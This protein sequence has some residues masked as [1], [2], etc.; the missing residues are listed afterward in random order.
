M[1]MWRGLVVVYTE[2]ERD[3]EMSEETEGETEDCA[4]V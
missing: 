1:A 4:D 3:G 2:N